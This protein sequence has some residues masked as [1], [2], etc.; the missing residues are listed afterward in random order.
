MRIIGNLTLELKNVAVKGNYQLK[1]PIIGV[2]LG[3]I[4]VQ[5]NNEPSFLPV[6]RIQTESS[7]DYE[8]ELIVP[9]LSAAESLFECMVRIEPTKDKKPVEETINVT[10]SPYSLML[11]TQHQ[12]AN[13]Q[14]P[15]CP[16]LCATVP[17]QPCSQPIFERLVPSIQEK[18]Y[19]QTANPR[20]EEIDYN[21]STSA[22][23]SIRVCLSFD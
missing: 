10:Y 1:R 3:K 11:I 22:S 5:V 14:K 7:N 21:A 9:D 2:D 16:F 17:L 20:G 15:H 12:C 8:L 19:P 4:E 6:I 18:P 23:G 13:G